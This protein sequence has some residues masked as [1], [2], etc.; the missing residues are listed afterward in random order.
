MTGEPHGTDA[1]AD[2][3]VDLGEGA[4]LVDTGELGEEERSFDNALRPR[5]LSEFVGQAKV[6]EQLQLLMDGARSRGETVDHTLFSGPPGLGKTTLASI[7]AHEMG[8]GF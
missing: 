2:A 8:V 7:V 4:R 6:K 5:T 3:V 1:D